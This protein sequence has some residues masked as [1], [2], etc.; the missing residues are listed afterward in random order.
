MQMLMDDLASRLEKE[1]AARQKQREGVSREP[2]SSAS[3]RR[4]SMDTPD[5]ELLALKTGWVPA[6]A[7]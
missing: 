3:S 7:M 5:R 2:S 6:S 1:T 4:E